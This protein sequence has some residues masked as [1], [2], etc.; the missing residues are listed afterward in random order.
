MEPSFIF[1]FEYKGIKIPSIHFSAIHQDDTEPLDYVALPVYAEC[2]FYYTPKGR[3]PRF[4]SEE[5]SIADER[6]YCYIDTHKR[7]LESLTEAE[8]ITI[9]TECCSE[10]RDV[11][12][13]ESTPYDTTDYKAIVRQA[14]DQIDALKDE[15]DLELDWDHIEYIEG[16]LNGSNAPDNFIWYYC[17]I[18]KGDIK[19]HIAPVISHLIANPKLMQVKEFKSA[20]HLTLQQ[21]IP[22]QGVLIEI[23]P[24]QWRN[25]QAEFDKQLSELK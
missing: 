20:I 25:L 16:I 19:V 22:A 2:L 14:L 24:N 15:V 12:I 11:V 23:N 3:S 10:F 9:I 13:Y 7:D 17:K 1:Y 21:M 8:I 18:V 6:V 4:R 5:A